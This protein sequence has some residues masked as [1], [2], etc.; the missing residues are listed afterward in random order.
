MT[1]DSHKEKLLDPINKIKNSSTD[2]IQISAHEIKCDFQKKNT[3]H[4]KNI[5]K[6]EKIF[7]LV[8]F[9]TNIFTAGFICNLF[10]TIQ[11]DVSFAYYLEPKM[12]IW[13]SSVQLISGIILCLFSPYITSKMT[14]RQVLVFGSFCYAL[15]T[16]FVHFLSISI[17]LVYI[18]FFIN[19]I[20]ASVILTVIIK[21]C[22]T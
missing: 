4:I 12:I 9:F 19:G 8:L 3:K 10:S 5:N 2:K 16:S 17:Y 21:F 22:N 15:G 6:C 1:N 7:N 13:T 14:L 11:P 20:G 18:G